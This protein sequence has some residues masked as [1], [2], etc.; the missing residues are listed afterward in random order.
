MQGKEDIQGK[1]RAFSIE[2]P[3]NK[4]NKLICN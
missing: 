3:F 4:I 2:G 1:E